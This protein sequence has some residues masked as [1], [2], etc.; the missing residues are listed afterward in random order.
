MKILGFSHLTFCTSK[1]ADCELGNFDIFFS[2]IPN[3]IEKKI[4]LEKIYSHHDLY[5][6][7]T[8]I[9]FII[10]KPQLEIISTVPV[11]FSNMNNLAEI[12]KKLDFDSMVE[13]FLKNQYQQ[14]FKNL[15]KYNIELLSYPGLKTIQLNRNGGNLNFNQKI[16]VPGL[17]S[18]CFYVDLIE[19]KI[20]EQFSN[21]FTVPFRLNLQSGSFEIVIARIGSWNVELLQRR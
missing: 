3:P 21:K 6:N 7:K 8:G 12:T 20:L 17:V 2:N 11:N 5:I 14:R 4:F 19:T 15:D 13:S 9:E 16:D 18:I 1:L 10:Y